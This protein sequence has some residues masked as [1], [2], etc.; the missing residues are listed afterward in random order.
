MAQEEFLDDPM[1]DVIEQW[2]Y[3]FSVLAPQTGELILDVGCNTGEAEQMTNLDL[4][5]NEWTFTRGLT[6]D[7]LDS[8]SEVELSE[9]PGRDLGPFWKQFRHVGRLQECYQD[10][11]NTG[12]IKF[13]YD[14]KRYR[15]SCSREALKNYLQELDREL[16]QAIEQVDWNMSIDWDG[17]NIGV[18]QH[19]MR[20]ASHEILHHGQW[21]LYARLMEKK[22]PPSWKA[23]GV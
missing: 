7:L 22:L 19:L 4:F 11:L 21:I 9:P 17:D 15:G 3:Y 5:K 10:A 12:R 16:L 1:P 14:H 13:D 6:L 2:R 18:F 23:W 8:L 20:M